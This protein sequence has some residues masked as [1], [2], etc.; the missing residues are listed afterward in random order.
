MNGRAAATAAGAAAWVVA[1]V[2]LPASASLQ[3]RILLLAPLV[4]V[5]LLLD[6][7]P[8][9]KRLLPIEGPVAL[10]AALPAAGCDGPADR[11]GRSRALGSVAG[12]RRRLGD[13]C[14]MA[15]TPGVARH[16]PAGTRRRAR[17]PGG[18][19]LPGRGRPVPLLRPAGRA[20]GRLLARDHPADG[21]SLPLRRFRA[22]ARGVAAGRTPV[23]RR[24]GRTGSCRGHPGD[25]RRVRHRVDRAECARRPR[26]RSLGNR[27][28]AR[29]PV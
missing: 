18:L 25:R 23:A 17:V 10:A 13:R 20:A 11:S 15:G 8:R 14:R 22:A 1:L 7:V 2:A 24:A 16:L 9:R 4:V 26:D 3:A 19:R 12:T 28:G 21:R 27:P 6:A 5:P 29:A